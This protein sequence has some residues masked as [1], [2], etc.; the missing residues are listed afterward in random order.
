MKGTILSLCFLLTFISSNVLAQAGGTSPESKALKDYTEACNEATGIEFP[1]TYSCEI[2]TNG[3]RGNVIGQEDEIPGNGPEQAGSQCR[4]PARLTGSCDEQSVIQI[5]KEN[6]DAF[7]VASCRKSEEIYREEGD[8]HYADLAVIQH[9]RKNGATCF[10]QAYHQDGK[11]IPSPKN[12]IPE[13]TANTFTWQNIEG[14]L[15]DNCVRCHDN[16]PLMRTPYMVN[17]PPPNNIQYDVDYSEKELSPNFSGSPYWFVGEEFSGWK[18][19]RIDVPNNTCLGCHRLSVSVTGDSANGAE[20]TG[21]LFATNSTADEYN[22]DDT[23]KNNDDSESNKYKIDHSWCSPIWMKPVFEKEAQEN[24][25]L[26]KQDPDETPAEIVGEV[27]YDELNYEAARDIQACAQEFVRR[28]N[29]RES[30]PN[31]ESV[32]VPPLKP[33]DKDGNP[34]PP[35]SISCGVTRHNGGPLRLIF[36]SEDEP[37]QAGFHDDPGKFLVIINPP[38]DVVPDISHYKIFVAAKEA[39]IISGTMVDTQFWMVVQPKKIAGPFTRRLEVHYSADGFPNQ[40]VVEQ[41]AVTFAPEGRPVDLMVVGDTS[42]SMLTE[43]K[44]D[45]AINAA[46]LYVDHAS[47]GDKLGVVSFANIAKLDFALTEVDDSVPEQNNVRTLAREEIKQWVASGSTALGEGLKLAAQQFEISG[48]QAE[49]QIWHMALLSDDNENLA[50][51][52]RDGP[53]GEVQQAIINASQKIQIDMVTLGTDAAEDLARDIANVTDGRYFRVESDE[54]PPTAINSLLPKAKFVPVAETF[55]GP[56]TLPNKLANLYKTMAEQARREERIGD[57]DGTLVDL[58]EEDDFFMQLESGLPE[59]LISVNWESKFDT[60]NLK[61]DDYSCVEMGGQFIRDDTHV[62]CRLDN[63][64]PGTIKI[65]VQKPGTLPPPP[66]QVT[67]SENNGAFVPVQALDED[68]RYKVMVSA[69]SHTNM[70]ANITN[71]RLTPGQRINLLVFMGD[72]AKILNAIVNAKIVFPNGLTIDVP[73]TDD[74]ENGDHS[75]NDGFYSTLYSLPNAGSYFIQYTATGVDNNG[76]PFKRNFFETVFVKPSLKLAAPIIAS[77]SLVVS[78]RSEVIASSG[79]DLV[80]GQQFE[81]GANALAQGDVI[82]DGNV[83]LRSFSTLDGDLNYSGQLNQQNNVTITGNVAQGNVPVLP[84]APR[85]TVNPGSQD[86]IVGNDQDVRTLPQAYKDLTLRARGTLHLSAGGEYHFNSLNIESNSKII[87]N[88]GNGSVKI[89]VAGNIKIGNFVEFE[90]DGIERL[91]IYS[92]GANTV[93]L[94]TDVDMEATIIAPNADVTV[95]SRSS[96]LN[97]AG[98]NVRIEPDAQVNLN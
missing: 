89:F 71:R 12:G 69:Y 5:I 36:P 77:G 28:Y 96:T 21:I 33:F 82:V 53:G 20:G 32:E 79:R 1:A 39:Q 14:T 75:A 18:T 9:N 17:V 58:G 84:V 56:E 57:W 35:S 59:V 87:V 64:A 52:W 65:T 81:L 42:G 44:I 90:G 19:Y 10:Y 60:L 98:K 22:R 3:K 25:E 37:V 48:G 67:S 49:N 43:G 15:A 11:L 30:L 54:Q 41:G 51:F 94:G 27:V 80:V 86:L 93:T 7:I 62:Q 23:S 63:P 16:G 72:T 31:G 73:L 13:D 8:T 74:G 97:I 76:V 46:T 55:N 91:F 45:A 29:N 26:S 92:N 68:I 95:F 88:A 61:I 34:N 66:P 83:N 38:S 2:S 40:T 4:F 47:D 50:P 6:E 78:D 24:C 70:F 85:F